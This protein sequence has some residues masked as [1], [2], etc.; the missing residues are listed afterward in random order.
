VFVL[1]GFGLFLKGQSGFGGVGGLGFLSGF[2]NIFL[3]ASYT[4]DV[5]VGITQRTRERERET[6]T[7]QREKKKKKTRETKR[8]RAIFLDSLPRQIEI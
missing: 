5:A 2:G 8:N 4:G 1:V 7:T 3:M 6:Q